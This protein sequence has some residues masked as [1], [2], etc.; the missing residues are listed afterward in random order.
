MSKA[1]FAKGPWVVKDGVVVCTNRSDSYTRVAYAYSG[2]AIPYTEEVLNN[3][4]LIA[5]AP[6]M[7]ELLEFI[8]E[9]PS[10]TNV[11][12]IRKLLAKAR[13]EQND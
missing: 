13:G 9:N 7:Y 2:H 11:I 5:A 4:H 10:E 8:S 1:K 6:E 3:A 12:E